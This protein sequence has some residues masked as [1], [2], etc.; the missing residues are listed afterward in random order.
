[1]LIELL[2]EGAAGAP[3]RP[4]VVSGDG[5]VSY[6]SCLARS[7][8]LAAGLRARS[9]TR[10]AAVVSGAADV[11]ALLCA[12]SATGSE[13]CLYPPGL[14]APA[15]TAQ[16]TRFDHRVVIADRSLSLPAPAVVPIDE[17]EADADTGTVGPPP[18]S[19]PVLILT[20]GTTGQPKGARHDWARLVAAA[21]AVDARPGTRW[22]LTYG[23]HQF[24]GI[25]LVLH[26]LAHATTLV[27]PP[28]P[29]PRDVIA[30]IRAQRV[31]HVS[32]TPTFWRLL[33]GALDST[34][35]RQLPLEQLTLGGEPVPG[36]LLAALASRFPDA[37]V[38]QVYAST[39]FGTAV[40]VRDGLAGL[41]LSVLERS[42]APVLLRVVDGELQARS[43]VGMLGFHGEGDVD[44]GWRP[45]GDLVEVRDGRIH[46]VGRASETI[47]VGG[48]KVHPLPV[49]EV[50]AAV[51]GVALAHA[52]GRPN[53]VTGEIV[54]VDVVARP[55]A[56]R[57]DLEDRIRDA[58]RSL[59]AAAQP[60]R[61]RFVDEIE[62][63]GHKIARHAGASGASDA[64]DAVGRR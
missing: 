42:D 53:P 38:S 1:V 39:E 19:A 31:T 36:P 23:L 27:V 9:V 51:D 50:V 55:D 28:S 49:E 21:R 52:Y 29:R 43:S 6:A 54:V 17:L 3:D 45:T 11:V 24:A 35:A 13:A 48:V 64:A 46:F 4:M 22:L 18:A 56:D 32:A 59:P 37:R 14:D 16:A 63:R 58:C 41:P 61:V 7:E 15:I 12:S 40:S 25:Q 47:N 5:S 44:D 26:A 57:A 30:T 62:Q 33:V 20:T 34:S 2:R 60:R 10:F 8:R